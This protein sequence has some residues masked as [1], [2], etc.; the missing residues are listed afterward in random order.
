MG[1]VKISREVIDYARSIGI[2]KIRSDRTEKACGMYNELYRKGV[3]V[4]LLAH[5][6][7]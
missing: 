6:T 1:A 4:A 3:K 2:A 5:G 7:C